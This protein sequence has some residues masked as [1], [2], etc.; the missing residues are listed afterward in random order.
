MTNLVA[1][2]LPILVSAVIVFI[3]SS[4]IWMATPLHKH[5]Y[6]NP[7][8]KEGVIL[9]FLRGAGLSPGVYYVPWCQGK[10]QKDPAVQAHMKAGPW[11]MITVMPGMPNMGKMLGLW[12]AHLVIVGVLV[13]Y[14]TGTAL[15]AG[16]A[17]LKVFQLAGVT[18]LIAHAAYALP[19]SIW[20]GQPWSQ[21][22]TRLIDGVVYSL[23]TAGVFGWLWPKAA[24]ISLPTP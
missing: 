1:L 22:P 12:F 18:A 5:D 6:K 24:G 4:V 19:M 21:L 14:V 23:L 8:D 16:A 20:H 2:W 13:A 10:D 15:P 17:Y 7:G 11:A 9:E 3:A